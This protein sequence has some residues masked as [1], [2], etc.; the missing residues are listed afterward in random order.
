MDQRPVPS[1]SATE[2]EIFPEEQ[3]PPAVKRPMPIYF[4]AAWCFL[5]L[6]QYTGV[7]TRVLKHWFAATD[8]AG[9]DWSS[10]RGLLF[11]L[12]I[13]HTVR[14]VQLKPFNRWFS[15]AFLLL[16]TIMT[17]VGMLVFSLREQ[18]PFP[19]IIGSALSGLFSLTSALYL[20]HRRFRELAIRFVAEREYPKHLRM[21]QKVSQKRILQELGK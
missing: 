11:I 5:G 4:I 8:L 16:R 21:M 6:I 14:L 10:L 7:L 2:Q 20:A 13:W 18:S 19:M 12:V 9:R 17:I 3:S 15:V 1:P